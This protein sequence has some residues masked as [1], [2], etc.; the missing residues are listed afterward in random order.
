MANTDKIHARPSSDR[1]I[2]LG[3]LREALPSLTP[4]MMI[5]G[6]ATRSG[7]GSRG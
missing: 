6:S 1:S 7:A 4:S 3:A 2:P 5:A